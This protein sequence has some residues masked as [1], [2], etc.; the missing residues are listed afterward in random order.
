MFTKKNAITLAAL[1]M[2]AAAAHAEVNLYGTLDVS[3]GRKQEFTG[4]VNGT[5]LKKASTT[6]VDSSDMSQS[7]FG[8][9][10]QEDLGDGLKATFKLESPLAVDTG[11]AASD[12]KFWSQNATVGLAGGFG[13][14]NVGRFENLFK[15]EGAAFNPFGASATFSPT[16][17]VAG[18]LAGS[19]SNGLSYVSPNLSGLT[20]S[21]QISLKE[22]DKASATNYNGGAVDLA[23]NYTAGP[24]G[25][26]LTYGD[27]RGTEGV[28]GGSSQKDRAWL[29]GASY[30]FGVLK[31]FGQYGQ[32]K[33]NYKAFTESGKAKFFQ[34]GALVPV[35]TAGSVLVSYGDDKFKVSGLEGT[36]KR[37]AFSLGYVQNLSKRTNVYAAWINT[38]DTVG[39]DQNPDLKGTTNNYAMGVR[40][41]F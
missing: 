36:D 7:Y 1:T 11:K 31:A 19:W 2:A 26:S 38:R 18:G 6:N 40:H 37:R 16:F 14:V 22:N 23:A 33:T 35:T 5:K 27:V 20:L 4:E 32:D 10:G 39:V 15:L 9:K 41:A 21:G 13:A 28:A 25:L 30:D 29:L 3:F 12:G 8:L 24:L 34:L 17:V